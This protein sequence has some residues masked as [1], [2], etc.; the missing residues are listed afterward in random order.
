MCENMSQQHYALS[1][2]NFY[3]GVGGVELSIYRWLFNSSYWR[4]VHDFLQEHQKSYLWT[5]SK[6]VLPFGS[7]ALNNWFH[8]GRMG[9]K[10]N[11]TVEWTDRHRASLVKISPLY[12]HTQS[13]LHKQNCP[14]FKQCGI[15]LWC[16]IYNT[17][18]KCWHLVNK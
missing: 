14:Q 13:S 6:F 10:W 11:T 1:C 7:I 3:L 12:I 2:I 5:K 4:K 15:Y 16:G 9:E 17:F 8:S 18:K